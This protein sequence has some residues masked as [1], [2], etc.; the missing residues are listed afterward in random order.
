MLFLTVQVAMGRG[1]GLF[2]CLNSD[3]PAFG[4]GLKAGVRSRNRV[5]L[6]SPDGR[7]RNLTGYD[8]RSGTRV[9]SPIWVKTAGKDP[10]LIAGSGRG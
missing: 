4:G 7:L 5:H 1:I 10:C 6:P 3:D 2:R 9:A 8:Y